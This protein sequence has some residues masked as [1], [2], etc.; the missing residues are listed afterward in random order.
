MS[1]HPKH[2]FDEWSTISAHDPPGFALWLTGQHGTGKSTQAKL[3]KSALKARG[4]KVEVI[5][6][7]TFSIGTQQELQIA[8][9]Q[10]EEQQHSPSYETFVIY[11]SAILIRSGIIAI[12][13]SISP[14]TQIRHYAKEQIGQFIEI[15]LHH[16]EGKQQLTPQEAAPPIMVKRYQTPRECELSLDIGN[17]PPER[18]ALRILNYLEQQSYIVPIWEEARSE[19]GIET[20][21]ARLSAL[22]YL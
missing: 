8:G 12:I 4:Y 17:E 2:I 19:E 15:D 20:L 1:F 10:N 6:N 13:A 3:L 21:K 16:P 7:Q 22:G 9:K 11:L 14:Y 18:T 5:D